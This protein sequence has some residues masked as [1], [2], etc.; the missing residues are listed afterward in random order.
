MGSMDFHFP[1]Q[2]GRWSP[3]SPQ[4]FATYANCDVWQC[5]H[6]GNVPATVWLRCDLPI[7]DMMI[8]TFQSTSLTCMMCSGSLIPILLWAS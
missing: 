1:F 2:E 5:Q 3:W 8:L 4:G 7:H 6:L